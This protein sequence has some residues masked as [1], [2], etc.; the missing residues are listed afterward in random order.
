M[1]LD[2]LTPLQ[3]DALREIGGIGAGHAATA[4]SQLVDRPVAL[5]VPR[6]DILKLAE[7]PYLFGGPERLV[8]AVYAQLLGDLTGGILFMAE[9]DNALSVV[10]LMHG[11]PVGTAKSMG[12]DEEALFSHVAS[13]LI[14][15]Y[16]AAV[17]RMTDIDVLPSGPAMAF[18][19]AGALLEAVITEVGMEATEAVVV[20]TAF[21]DEQHSVEAALFFVPNPDSLMVILRRLGL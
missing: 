17:A 21:I 7:V 9:R 18:D 12:K 10:D 16:L 19:M 2:S 4:L 8:G 13:I 3:L 15:A 11:H 5:E 20:R 1:Q 6:L 14:A